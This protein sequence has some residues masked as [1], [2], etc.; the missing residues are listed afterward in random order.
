MIYWARRQHWALVDTTKAISVIHQNHDYSHLPGGARH[1]RLPET[2]D[3]IRLAGGRRTIFRLTDALYDFDGQKLDRKPFTWE[4]FW[5]EVEIFP[6]V[7]MHSR[8]L[9][10]IFFAL[11][12]PFKAYKETRQWLKQ[13]NKNQ[14][15]H[16]DQE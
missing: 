4:K 15:P 11:F 7:T 2:S 16:D 9:G 5:R 8:L 1:Y 12:H 13:R 3:N 6:L 14:S 10:W